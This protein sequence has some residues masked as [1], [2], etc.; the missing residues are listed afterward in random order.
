MWITFRVVRRI[1]HAF[2]MRW[3]VPGFI[4]EDLLGFGGSGEVWRARSRA[5][6]ETVAVKRLPGAAAPGLR[7]RAEREAALLAAVSHPHLVGLREVLVVEADVVLVLDHL[8]GGSLAGVLAR[9]SR[10]AP[11]E[12]VTVLAPIAAAL[13]HA[14]DLGLVHAD[15]TP[16]NIL[17]TADGRPV[18]TDL[19]TS[20][21]IGEDR[22][23]EATAEYVDPVV[24]RGAAPAPAS[25]V[26]GL[27]AV[28]FHALAG[29][30]IW[31]A[32][33]VT[34][35]LR[36][37]REGSVPDLRSLAP[38]TP[39]PLIEALLRALSADPAHRGSAAELALDVRYA[40]EPDPV[41]LGVD[42]GAG[43]ARPGAPSTGRR[44]AAV[45]HEVAV[46]RFPPAE[47]PTPRPDRARRHRVRTNAR[48]SRLVTGVIA[49]VL[50]VAAVVGAVWVGTRWAGSAEP[51]RTGASQAAAAAVDPASP[52][53]W[54]SLLQELYDSRAAAFASADPSAL[55]DVYTSDSPQLATDRS[56]IEVM[57]GQQQ[58]LDGFAPTVSFV[59]VVSAEADRVRLR[60]V[61]SFAAFSVV[62]GSAVTPDPG[63][64]S[65]PV[66]V[67]MVRTPGGW[68]IH[69]AELM[70]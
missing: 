65:H 59:E 63:R 53:Q 12:V 46:P 23:V 29:V 47:P 52:A 14:H 24:A 30:P 42:S 36:V 62:A 35:T 26:F 69:T 49:A 48:R 16:G 8:A 1:C 60:V 64:G 7:E 50:G 37:A 39:E 21:V 32:A 13:Q 25:D 43:P 68:R 28:A 15:I 2:G 57:A 17:F 51:A 70:P 66:S 9:R 3:Q 27:A 19:G 5:T 4:L 20:R 61:D 54:Q 38:E 31:N 58:R 22:E 45:T 67:L 56:T 41:D 10:L 11:G 6:G 40:C 44:P 18:L 33:S 55:S 34:E